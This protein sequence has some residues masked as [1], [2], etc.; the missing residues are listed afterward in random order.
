MQP[1]HNKQ[2]LLD[3]YH[4]CTGTLTQLTQ[5][6]TMRQWA[7]LTHVYLMEGTHTVRSLAYTFDIPKPAVCRALDALSA[8]ELLKRHKDVTDG[9]SITVQKT[10]KG[11]AFLNQ[12]TDILDAYYD[13]TR[14]STVP[15]H[16]HQPQ[17]G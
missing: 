8:L 1:P 10:M 16:I 6:L 7:M 9:R 13:G 15:Y 17:I 11:I 2:R 3:W 5:E 14:S 12:F 4:L